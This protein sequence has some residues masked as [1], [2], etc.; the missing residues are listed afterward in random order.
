MSIKTKSFRGN[1]VEFCSQTM[2]M[3]IMQKSAINDVIL[4]HHGL[5]RVLTLAVPVVSPHIQ[6][7]PKQR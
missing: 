2:T 3:M 4:D 6:G 1:L 5:P 7:V